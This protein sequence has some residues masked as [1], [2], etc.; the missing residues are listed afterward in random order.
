[1]VR[2][3]RC[4]GGTSRRRDPGTARSSLPD[5]ARI[6]GSSE[7]VKTDLRIRPEDACPTA[8][9]RKRRSTVSEP[10]KGS[11]ARISRRGRDSPHGAAAAVAAEKPLH[12]LRG[13]G[14]GPRVRCSEHPEPL[15]HDRSGV[16]DRDEGSGRPGQEGRRGSD[17]DAT[18][19]VRSRR[20]RPRCRTLG[21]RTGRRVRRPG[22]VALR[23][24]TI[25]RVVI[26]VSGEA[27]VDLAT[28]A[29]VAFAR[30]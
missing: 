9:A 30:Q 11:A 15:L 20:R 16:G 29:K 19:E 1:V 2:V 7:R 27:F 14:G 18:G 4:F 13:R 26:D 3:I 5:D 17:P 25:K 6:P 23:R 12:V 21:R 24:G 8:W 10:F 28:E 22:S